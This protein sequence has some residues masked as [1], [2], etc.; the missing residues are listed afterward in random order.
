MALKLYKSSCGI[1]AMYAF[2]VKGDCNSVHKAY[3]IVYDHIHKQ[4]YVDDRCEDESD[5]Y[6]LGMTLTDVYGDEEVRSFVLTCNVDDIDT[7]FEIRDDVLKNSNV[8]FKRSK[9]IYGLSVGNGTAKMISHI[10][11]E[12]GSKTVETCICRL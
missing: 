3:D 11:N 1:D 8:S 7:I 5:T 10:V 2:E 12:S 9:L 6:I 4:G